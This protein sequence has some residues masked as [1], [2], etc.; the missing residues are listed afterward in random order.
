MEEEW[1]LIAYY[2][3]LEISNFGNVRNAKTKRK[4]TPYFKDGVMK[5]DLH[6]KLRSLSLARL[7]YNHFADEEAPKDCKVI[8]IDKNPQNCRFDNLRLRAGYGMIPTPEQLEIFN[9]Q[10][11]RC[12]K[13]ILFNIKCIKPNTQYWG[14]Y[15]V[16]DLIQ[17]CVMIIYQALPVYDFK[18]KFLTF[19]QMIINR[20]HICNKYVIENQEERKQAMEYIENL[21]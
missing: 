19:C 12:V 9:N 2:P 14:G 15:E 16:N 21:M 13:Y 17:D 5:I 11:Y 6:R 7:V 4:H 1:S 18:T 3:L 20:W 10:V 8:H